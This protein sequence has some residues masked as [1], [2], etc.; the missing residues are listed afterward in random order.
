MKKRAQIELTNN[1]GCIFPSGSEHGEEEPAADKHQ[2]VWHESRGNP[3]NDVEG[4][5]KDH[6]RLATK[7]EKYN[8]VHQVEISNIQAAPLI[9][10]KSFI[11]HYCVR[12]GIDK[13]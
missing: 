12:N 7:S 8:D 10:C 13:Q 9:S 6:D 1:E 3:Y 5:S 4:A 2:I 11:V